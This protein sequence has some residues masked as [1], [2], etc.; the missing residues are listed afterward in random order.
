M[1]ED[2]SN[3]FILDLAAKLD[4]C[5]EFQCHSS[6]SDVVSFPPYFGHESTKEEDF[7][8][9]LDERTGASLKLTVLNEKGRIWTM[10]AG[11]GASV[12]YADTICD[13]GYSNE[14]GNYGEYSGSPTK[15]ATYEY[16]VTIIKLLLKYPLTKEEL[17]NGKCKVL[18]IGGG[19]ANFTDVAYTFLGIIDALK[20]YKNE[21]I[22]QKTKIFV[23]R[24]GPN[25]QTGLKNIKQCGIDCDFDMQ[26]FGP[27]LL[28]LF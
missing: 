25:Y 1:K 22:K 23:R 19:I 11:G 15:T 20:E 27:E 24:G 5:A 7:I 14:L 18:I 9:S 28:Y 10:V 13:L 8:H 17:N 16:A 2:L 3:I 4:Q 6:W 12:I 21:L 26:V